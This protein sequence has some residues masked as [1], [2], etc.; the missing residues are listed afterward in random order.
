MWLYGPVRIFF[1]IYVRSVIAWSWLCAYLILIHHIRIG[2]PASSFS[3]SIYNYKLILVN[4][5]VSFHYCIHNVSYLNKENLTWLS[6]IFIWFCFLNLFNPTNNA[7]YH[8]GKY[9]KNLF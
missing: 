7:S 3:S 9:E 8:F 4:V 5:Q 2:I 1:E 6:F